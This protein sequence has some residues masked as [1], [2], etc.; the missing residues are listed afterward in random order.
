MAHLG[1]DFF[2]GFVSWKHP[3][4]GSL[5]TYPGRRINLD[6]M[7]LLILQQQSRC[8]VSK[9]FEVPQQMVKIMVTG[10]ANYIEPIQMRVVF[11]EAKRF[12]ETHNTGK[13][14]LP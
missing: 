10:H 4:K 3:A 5:F 8:G 7:A 2:M 6:I 12:A 1:H 13:N 11:F 14:R 9:L